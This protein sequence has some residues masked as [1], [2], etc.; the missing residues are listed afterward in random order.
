MTS[1]PNFAI[2][3]EGA[4]PGRTEVFARAVLRRFTLRSVGLAILVSSVLAVVFDIALNPH[5]EVA[6]F[7]PEPVLGA[8]T[9]Y[10]TI[11]IATMIADEAYA[12]GASRLRAYAT[13]IVA[14]AAVGAVLMWH[15]VN[16]V[17]GPI[18]FRYGSGGL[19]LILP[20]TGF[21]SALL[22]GSLAVGVYVN[23]RTA[24]AAMRRMQ[25]A[26]QARAVA[27]R[28]TLESRLQVIQARVEPRF[29]F[30]S[31]AQVRDLYEIDAAR[32]STMLDDLIAYL[33]TAL[34]HLRRSLSTLGREAEL[35]RAYVDVTR[36]GTGRRFDLSVSIDSGVRET[37]L[38]GML[39][40]PLAQHA[41]TQA[42][43]LSIDARKTGDRLRVVFAVDGWAFAPGASQPALAAVLE[44]LEALYGGAAGLVLEAVPAGGSR[45]TLELP[46][47][48]NND[49]EQ[50]S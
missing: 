41:L 45:A 47:H 17:M 3:L 39:L 14:G 33:R 25:A 5:L 12:R 10:L 34:P 7:R 42:S 28:R 20:V 49:A 30:D 11:F 8:L 22:I 26:E 6:L 31:L 29:L 48:T 19:W 2:I 4:S 43:V 13:A 27:H 44:R 32:A 24:L 18:R 46:L 50:E 16:A 1:T 36:A 15:V 37:P 23:W 40:L 38:P 9:T 35:A 21:V